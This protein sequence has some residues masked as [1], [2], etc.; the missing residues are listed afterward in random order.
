M[1]HQKTIEIER[2]QTQ[3]SNPFKP[4]H[5]ADLQA[6]GIMVEIAIEAGLRSVSEEE[7]VQLLGFSIPSGTTGLI[8]PYDN[9]FF[10]VKLFPPLEGEKGTMRYAQPKLS[11][12]KLYVPPASRSVLKNPTV[13]LTITEG[14][15]KS[16][17]GVQEGILGIGIGG[18][19]NWLQNG[20]PIADLDRIAWVER[21]VIIV[22][23]S[24]VWARPDLL[25]AVYALGVEL[26]NRGAKVTICIIPHEGDKKRGLDD[27][28]IA[29]GRNG[30]DDLVRINLRHN[31][32]LPPRPGIKIG[33]RVTR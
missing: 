14:E 25:R 16:L 28:L 6:S 1:K 5:L 19:W 7:L 22:P 29:H 9:E 3:S 18:L 27:F 8:F 12:V 15:K 10:R 32:F 4:D 33:L 13:A 21:P 11:G 2:R 30:F 23:D 24:D 31:C 17:K 20:Q 26:E